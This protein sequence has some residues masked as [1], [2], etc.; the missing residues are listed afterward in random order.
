MGTINQDVTPFQD[1]VY[2]LVMLD[3]FRNVH[4]REIITVN[5]D[6]KPVF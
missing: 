4:P 5:V 1:P 3:T 2:R 6:L